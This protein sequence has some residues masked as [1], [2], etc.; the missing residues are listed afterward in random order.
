[1][2]VFS[3]GTLILCT[4]ACTLVSPLQAAESKKIDVKCH[5]EVVGGGEMIRFWKI[6]AEKLPGFTQE[7]VGARISKISGKGKTSVYRA[8]ECVDLRDEFKSL[9]ARNLDSKTPK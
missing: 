5:V 9:I 1:M 2:P 4:M 8:F 3:R 7:I 6:K